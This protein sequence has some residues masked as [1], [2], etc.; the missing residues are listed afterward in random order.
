MYDTSLCET[1]ITIAVNIERM[2]HSLND[3]IRTK[4]K[5]KNLHEKLIKF[6]ASH[7]K[8]I[9][10]SNSNIS[11]IILFLIQL[12]KLK[13]KKEKNSIFRFVEQFS[14]TYEFYI[15][16]CFLW[17]LSTISVTLCLIKVEMVEYQFFFDKTSK[18]SIIINLRSFSN[19]VSRVSQSGRNS[20]SA[21]HNFLVFCHRFLFL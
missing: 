8:G 17:C 5:I 3:P 12:F 21:D 11:N 9:Q 6:I 10:L 2:V 14:D 13:M 19:A 16:E 1:L 15:I 18:Q 4:G 7:A 20:A